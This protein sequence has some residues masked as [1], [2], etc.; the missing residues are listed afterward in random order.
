MAQTHLSVVCKQEAPKKKG[1]ASR[2]SWQCR[3][4]P[5][6][7]PWMGARAPVHTPGPDVWPCLW[8]SSSQTTLCQAGMP[9]HPAP[10][11]SPMNG[12]GRR[13]QV[14]ETTDSL[15][16]GAIKEGCKQFRSRLLLNLGNMQGDMGEGT[17]GGRGMGGRE[18][19]G[20]GRAGSTRGFRAT[21]PPLLSLFCVCLTP[22]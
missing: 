4:A 22:L 15:H 20:M 19:A 17:Q 11:C 8:G 12:W 7:R 18:R 6:K 5:I 10:P 2:G 16:W 13:P 21:V 14:P 9:S 1:A 3:P